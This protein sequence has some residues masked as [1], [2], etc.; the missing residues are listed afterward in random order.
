[1]LCKLIKFDFHVLVHHR[2]FASHESMYGVDGNAG[3]K[4]MCYPAY[5]T[6]FLVDLGVPLDI[7]AVKILFGLYAYGPS[8]VSVFV[9]D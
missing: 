4:Y 2:M 3:T 7:K 9:I 5:D 8:E 6:W 1:M